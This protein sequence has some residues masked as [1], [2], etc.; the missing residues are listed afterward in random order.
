M[1]PLSFMI[2]A[3]EASGDTLAAELVGHLRQRIL[4]LQSANT[5][6]ARTGGIHMA[7]RFFG[8][9]GGRMEAAGVETAFDLTQH[10]VIGLGDVVWKYLQFKRMF[11]QLFALAVER[12]PDVIV[13]VDFSGFNRRLAGALK[14]WGTR[15]RGTFNNWNPK[16]IQ[17]VS[18]QVWASRPGRA[19]Q[20]AEI[21]D[22]VLSI[23]PFEK[24]WYA[25]RV[26]HLRVEYVGHPIMD[27][28]HGFAP[29]RLD[30]AA[31]SPPIGGNG[32]TVILILPG[33]RTAELRRHLPVMLAAAQAMVPRM[34][35]AEF[36]LV[37]PTTP[38][39]DLARRLVNEVGLLTKHV[40][41]QSGQ[42]AQSL[43]E[44]TLAIASTGTITMDCAYFGVP[45]VAIYRT[46]WSTY[47]V[48]KR[49]IQ[50]PFLAMPNIIAGETIFPE[51][52]QNQAT[53][54][55]ISRE[56]L[57][58]LGNPRRQK[59]I[60]IELARVIEQLGPGGAGARAAAAILDTLRPQEEKAPHRLNLHAGV[61]STTI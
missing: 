57:A 50:V 44:A 20:M 13:G 4:Q 14:E 34:P 48:G 1:K 26:P 60:K 18:P 23:F 6:A 51:L 40:R 56:A 24:D 9:G 52:I 36:R 31:A 5:D 35:N 29:I 10:S 59:E 33:S 7:P 12:R 19:Y 58:I 49:I 3:G 30:D 43:S 55:R 37:L 39:A 15:R 46:S 17:F 54:E 2:V 45:T 28:Y 38:L 16:L 32:K 22:L 41:I 8:A 61:A 47:Q 27:R 11:R 42:L 25:R 53:E 21:Y